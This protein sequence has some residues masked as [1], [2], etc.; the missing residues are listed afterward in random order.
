MGRAPRWG[1]QL[2][3]AAH[4]S[5]PFLLRVP[6]GPK[7]AY[8]VKLPCEPAWSR[9]LCP[10]GAAGLRIDIAIEYTRTGHS[11]RSSVFRCRLGLSAVLLGRKKIRGR[12]VLG[13]TSARPKA[14]GHAPKLIFFLPRTITPIVLLLESHSAIVSVHSDVF[15]LL[16]PTECYSIGMSFEI[17]MNS[18]GNHALGLSP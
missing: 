4:S 18:R 9:D 1:G 13:N 3:G 6:S 12:A 14:F 10:R 7:P 2:A 5:K 15:V 11:S 16:C 17:H 8:S